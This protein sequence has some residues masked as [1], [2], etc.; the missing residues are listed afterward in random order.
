MKSKNTAL[1]IAFSSIMCHISAQSIEW[2]KGFGGDQ[3]EIGSF[4]SVDADGNIYTVGDFE[5]TVDFNP[6]SASFNLTSNG[7]N[8]IFIQKMDASGNFLWAESFGNQATDFATGLVLDKAGNVYISGTFSISADFDPGAGTYT[9]TSAGVADVFV[10][11]LSPDGDL[12]WARSFGGNDNDY[13]NYIT[14]DPDENILITGNFMGTA[15]FDPGT[16]TANLSALG[17]NDIFVVK[18]DP[19]GKLLWA[20]SFGGSGEDFGYAINADAKGNVF[21]TG[22]FSETVDFDPGSGTTSLSSV[23]FAD[24]FVHKMDATGKFLWARTFGGNSADVATCIIT[25]ASGNV[26][27]AGNFLELV[28]FD[29]GAGNYDITSAGGRDVFIQKLDASGNFVWVKTFGGNLDDKP[30]GLKMDPSRNLYCA[31]VFYATADFDPGTG[32]ANLTS[33]GFADNFVQNL[34]SAGNFN[35]AVSFG[36]SNEDQCFEIHVDA[37]YNIYTTGAFSGA[38]DFDPGTGTIKITAVNGNDIF[39]QKMKQTI[40]GW[41]D[42]GTGIDVTIYPNPSNHFV[43][44]SFEKIINNVELT[45]TDLQGKVIYNE[46]FGQLQHKQLAIDGGTGVYFLNIKTPSS[47]CVVKLLKD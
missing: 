15:D 14:L 6:G 16:G 41:L 44:I 23:G 20:N 26:Y 10:L 36:G 38:T 2:A 8:D 24:V 19:F 18:L 29:P 35:W 40:T 32:T 1:F 12:I 17:G 45:V 4:I 34:D 39:V 22:Y 9:L 3:N 27:T 11:K 43:N 28:D 33:K 21:T 5:A 46:Y 47:N 42:M 37:S 30:R 7:N 25:D 31:G 13:A